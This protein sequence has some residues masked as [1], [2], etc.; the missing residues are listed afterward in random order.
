MNF[1]SDRNVL[2]FR[3]HERAFLLRPSRPR[4]LSVNVGVARTPLPI[5]RPR[6]DKRAVPD[7]YCILSDHLIERLQYDRSSQANQISVSLE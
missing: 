5:M 7:K 1:V 4:L 2:E 3:V 6:L